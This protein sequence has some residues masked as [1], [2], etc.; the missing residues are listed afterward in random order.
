M[1]IAL[2]VAAALSLSGCNSGLTPGLSSAQQNLDRATTAC[3]MGKQY[4]NIKNSGY[5]QSWVQDIGLDGKP[6][7]C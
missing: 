6:I 7:A 3:R 1:K 2:I 4:L 5:S